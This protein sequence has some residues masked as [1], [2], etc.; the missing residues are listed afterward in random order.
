MVGT[1]YRC[2]LCST[3]ASAGARGGG[4]VVVD[5][6]PLTEVPAHARDGR[7]VARPAV[8][9]WL[10]AL[11]AVLALVLVGVPTAAMAAMAVVAVAAM[12]FAHIGYAGRSTLRRH[13]CRARN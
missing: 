6:P 5:H 9:G 7:V 13:R 12:L 3:I 1:G 2:D 10:A 8:S 11:A 4:P